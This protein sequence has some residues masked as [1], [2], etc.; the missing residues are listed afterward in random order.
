VSRATRPG[1]PHAWWPAGLFTAALTLA[2]GLHAGTDQPGP[3][4]SPLAASTMPSAVV[5]ALSQATAAAPPAI[6]P[7]VYRFPGP[8]K[9]L[10]EVFRRLDTDSD[11]KLSADE[12]RRVVT[13][14]S[15]AP[16]DLDAD[17]F[18]SRAEFEISFRRVYDWTP[19]DRSL[20]AF[21][22][23]IEGRRLL[24][25]GYSDKALSVARS[26][27][28]SY[29]E[30][31]D[32]W[33]QLGD[34]YSRQGNQDKAVEAYRKALELS[35]NF[36][37]AWF[38]IARFAPAAAL[39]S[40]EHDP[41][42]RALRLL[43]LRFEVFGLDLKS[44]TDTV[45][46]ERLM[47]SVMNR[48]LLELRQPE[49]ALVLTRWCRE[50][51]G[52]RPR[53]EALGLLALAQTGHPEKALAEVRSW[54]ETEHDDFYYL[55]AQA[56]ILLSLQRPME[57]LECFRQALSLPG[58]PIDRRR[59]K[60]D[61]FML[62]SNLGRHEEAE[63]LLEELLPQMDTPNLKVIA[64]RA[65]ARTGK[66]PKAIELCREAISASTCMPS[67]WM[68]LARLHALAG[69]RDG[70]IRTLREAIEKCPGPPQFLERARQMLERAVAGEALPTDPPGPG[71]GGP[72]FGG[73]APGP[74][75]PRFGGPAGP[76]FGGPAG[77][78]FGGPSGPMPRTSGTEGTGFHGPPGTGS[79][80]A[81]TPASR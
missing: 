77:P 34:I 73:A 54:V 23:V 81:T 53:L 15:R 45:N 57:A 30:W 28:Q 55:E 2:G 46:E 20:L 78:R 58:Q 36:E 35:P 40:G 47:F 4:A 72:G 7:A 69:D 26:A 16:R 80:G 24:V 11:G 68:Q 65:L 17:G 79:S 61:L 14:P 32:N 10:G 1:L 64:G 29:P 49:Q 63:T 9:A 70:Y 13:E 74:A 76:S 48:F 42:R 38:S 33:V 19:S 62:L 41:L 43:T 75:G 27:V 31:S 3:Q 21:R 52:L 6:F 44:P 5:H 25:D 71:A 37:G 51:M 67:E 12:R 18:V 8:T 59:M 22:F 39:A 56:R 66:L 60:L 50:N